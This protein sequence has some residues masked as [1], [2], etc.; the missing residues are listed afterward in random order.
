LITASGRSTP[1]GWVCRGD[2]RGVI[3]DGRLPCTT[4][5]RSKVGGVNA[6]LEALRSGLARLGRH[7]RHGGAAYG[8]LLISLLLTA[9]AFYYVRNNVEAQTRARFDETTQATQEAIERRT[10]AYLDAMF[11]ARGLFY[12]SEA[13][14][15]EEWDDYVEGIEPGSR[16]EGLQALSF[17]EYVRP[18]EREAFA[19]RVREEGLPGMR[20]DVDPGGERGAYFPITY[21]G[22]LDEANQ[23][24]LN[25]DF[26]AEAV[27]REA[28]DR[29]RDAGEPRATRMVYVL[30]EAPEGSDADLALRTGFVVYLPVYQEGEPLGTV[31]E[32]RGALRGFVVGSFA[33]DELFSGVFRGAFDPQ[34]DFEV[35]DGGDPASSPLL[36]D[37][38][39]IKRAGERG[40]DALYSNESGMEVAG[41]EWSLYYATLRGFEEQARS[42][43]PAFVLASG[44]AVSLLLFGI[45]W[46]LVRSRTRA[47]RASKELEEANR[48]LEGAN[49]E[50]EAFSYSVS[51]DLRAPLRTIDGFSQILLE[52]HADQLDEEGE[53]YLGRV[54]AASQHMDNLIDDLLDLSRV[55]RGP[56]R[57]ETVDL[58]ALA[59]GII[60]ELRRS[61]PEREVEFVTEEGILAFA[62]SNLVTVALENL[63]SNAWKF[64]SREEKARIEFGSVPRGEKRA[65]FVRDNGVGFDEAYSDKLFGAFQRL[66]AR[67]EFEGT[68]IG[69]ATVARI[70]RRHGGK[71]WARGRVGEGA[72]FFFTLD[73]EHRREP[74]LPSKRAEIA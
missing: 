68:G 8:V 74:S 49:R 10:K 12:A 16:F 34:I 61:E 65:Y 45:T 11:G 57:R 59:T 29:A 32:R 40:P 26:Y 1:T 70:V 66:H 38:D 13:V 48:E 47:V 9:L 27:H 5:P 30:T 20:P 18:E 24:M 6:G 4:S 33:I 58:S 2:D 36:Y 72:T 42:S 22:P 15:P 52:D 55:S 14:T 41:R 39:G 51:H 21:T 69:L 17:A 53:D 63:I 60:D 35:Y 43:L 23:N 64:T 50:L 37:S 46:M 3:D 25:H 56:L 31:A 19:R 54:R 28:M 73:G 7:L 44:A 71:V 62:D 67:E